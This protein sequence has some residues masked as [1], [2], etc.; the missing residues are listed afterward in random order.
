MTPNGNNNPTRTLYGWHFPAS[1]FGALYCTTAVPADLVGTG[2]A[3]VEVIYRLTNSASATGVW[4][5]AALGLPEGGTL[6]TGGTNVSV[7]Q[8][9]NQNIITRAVFTFA[10]GDEV[11]RSAVGTRT[12][13]GAVIAIL[14]FTGTDARLEALS[15]HVNYTSAR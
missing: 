3:S 1:T 15:I 5:V 11:F 8:T 4:T 14:A 6:P 7:N 13:V 2:P 10:N 9:S 12:S